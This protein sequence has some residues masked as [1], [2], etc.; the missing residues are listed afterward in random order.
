[1]A[2]RLVLDT[3]IFI[4]ALISPRGA[5]RELVNRGLRGEFELIVSEKLL[6]EVETRLQR[7]KFR[8]WFTLDEA[9][10]YVAAITLAGTFVADRPDLELPMVCADADDNFLVALAQDAEAD[11]LV[12]GDKKVLAVEVPNLIVG[13]APYALEILSYEHEW[14][15]EFLPSQHDAIERQID[16]EGTRPLVEVYRLFCTAIAGDGPEADMVLGLTV[17]PETKPLFVR[18][19]DEVRSKLRGRGLATRPVYASPEV[20]HLK[21]PPDPGETLRVAH[22]GGV[23]L[24][25]NTIFM[26]LV[27]CPDL[28]DQGLPFDHWRVFALGAPINPEEILP[29]TPSQ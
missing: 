8:R 20:A 1:M 17:V 26:T 12:S 3:N 13:K 19:R 6:D 5:I 2:R 11:M 4:S 16:A 24:P 7:D 25:P 27:R 22:V 28:D 9:D 18:G 21:L 14:G 15:S 23:A 29:R 10:D